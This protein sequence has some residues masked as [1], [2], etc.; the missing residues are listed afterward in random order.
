MSVLTCSV[1]GFNIL[2]LCFLRFFIC[3]FVWLEWEKWAR[4]AP[5]GRWSGAADAKG[6]RRAEE[7]RQGEGWGHGTETER[8]GL[9]ESADER[10]EFRARYV[11]AQRRRRAVANMPERAAVRGC[12]LLCS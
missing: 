11:A 10:S 2:F 1:K 12:L 8:S 9:L 6:G 4:H 7:R 5:K 3:V